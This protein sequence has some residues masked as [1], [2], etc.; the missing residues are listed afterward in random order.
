L[1]LRISRCLPKRLKFY[2]RS[3]NKKKKESKKLLQ[4]IRTLKRSEEK[5][6]PKNKMT[7]NFDDP[8]YHITNSKL[9]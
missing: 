6:D 9:I 7:L 8:K 3:S 4:A 5:E 2:S 1:R